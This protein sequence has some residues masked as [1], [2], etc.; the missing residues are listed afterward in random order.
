MDAFYLE[1]LVILVAQSLRL[2]KGRV[3]HSA[4][5]P[6][7]IKILL[8]VKSIGHF[9]YVYDEAIATVMGSYFLD[10]TPKFGFWNAVI[11][12]GVTTRIQLSSEYSP[13]GEDSLTSI[14]N[15]RTA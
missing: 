15:P 2:H 12:L 6:P 11:G 7:P 13:N 4:A 3:P 14:S 1:S 9:L 8:L 10:E 5:I